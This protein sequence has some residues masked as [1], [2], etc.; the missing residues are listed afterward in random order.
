[1][2]WTC[3]G[4]VESDVTQEMCRKILALHGRSTLSW[5]CHGVHI[6][7]FDPMNCAISTYFLTSDLNN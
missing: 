1:M 3:Y 5:F 4:G 7:F 2:N 6:I